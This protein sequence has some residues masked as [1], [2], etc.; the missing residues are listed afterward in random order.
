M[1]A[2]RS[3]GNI[4]CR[5]SL[6]SFFETE[7]L[8]CLPLHTQP[9]GLEVSVNAPFYPSHLSDTHWN[10][11][12]LLS[13]LAFCRFWEC[14]FK[15]SHLCAKHFAYRTIS[16]VLSAFS[17]SFS[18]YLCNTR[19]YV[20]ASL[21]MRLLI[22]ISLL[23]NYDKA[24]AFLCITMELWALWFTHKGEM[25]ESSFLLFMLPKQNEGYYYI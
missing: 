10:H 1:C 4:G 9:F 8:F 24:V 6:F 20:K 17:Y 23:I 2:H 16:L 21:L 14:E 11:R 18:K 15:S 25:T 13:L 3:V 7:C 19:R 5:S 12:F 22:N